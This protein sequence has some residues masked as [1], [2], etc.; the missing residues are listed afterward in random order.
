MKNLFKLFGIAAIVAVIGLSVAGCQTDTEDPTV[1]GV[2]VSPATVSVARGG[3]HTF[4]ATVTGTNNHPTTVT[5]AIVQTNTHAQTTINATTGVLNVAAAETLNTLTIRATSTFDTSRNGT[6]TVTLTGGAGEGPGEG[7]GPGNGTPGQAA[8][9]RNI[10]IRGAQMLMVGPRGRVGR[11]ATQA[12]TE[13]TPFNES[14]L[15]LYMQD[16][17]GEWSEVTMTGDGGAL[18]VAAPSEIMELTG[19]WVVMR[20]DDGTEHLVCRDQGIVFSVPGGGLTSRQHFPDGL[21]HDGV[22]GQGNH[23]YIW[24]LSYD[25]SLVHAV[26]PNRIF[27]M[28]RNPSNNWGIAEVNINVTGGSATLTHITP[29]TWNV[30]QF[31]VDRAGNILIDLGSHFM[32]R[33]A[34][35]TGDAAQTTRVPNGTGNIGDNRRHA[36]PQIFSGLDGEI[37]LIVRQVYRDTAN[38][39]TP[40]LPYQIVTHGGVRYFY[41]ARRMRVYRMRVV[42]GTFTATPVPMDGLR[43]RALARAGL[44]VTRNAAGWDGFD[45]ATHG[46]FLGTPLTATGN[47]VFN[48]IPLTSAAGNFS[49]DG[50]V[51]ALRI[52]TDDYWGQGF[53]MRHSDFAFR[54]GD[55]V[56]I[57]GTVTGLTDIQQV[58]LNS[59]PGAY[60]PV[61]GAR[62]FGDGSFELT[63][64]LTQADVTSIIA[65]NPAA[66]RFEVRGTGATALVRNV[67]VVRPNTGVIFDLASSWEFLG[68]AHHLLDDD[69]LDE[70]GLVRSWGSFSLVDNVR[71]LQVVTTANWGQGVDLSQSEFDLSPGDRVSVRG[72][73][74]GLG[75]GRVTL[76][77]SP[78]AERFVATHTGSAQYDFE[79]FEF[80]VTLTQ[81]DVAAIN[82]ATP[83]ALRLEIRETGAT[84]R[85]HNIRVVRA[86]D[87][88]PGEP[89]NGNGNGAGN[90]NGNG[91]G[92]EPGNGNGNG[93][94]N[95]GDPVSGIA[96]NTP[97][98]WAGIDR[99]FH[100]QD[101]TVIFERDADLDWNSEADGIIISLWRR[102][103]QHRISRG[104][105]GGISQTQLNQLDRDA[106]A[107]GATEV[108]ITAGRRIVAINPETNA[109]RDVIHPIVGETLHSIYRT[110]VA[111]YDVIAQVWT[112]DGDRQLLQFRPGITM[113]RVL[114]AD[115]NEGEEITMVRLR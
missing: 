28:V 72:T 66:L 40:P 27:V 115:L 44:P 86:G 9:V 38:W 48:N 29:P 5:W 76:N 24:H 91:N 63:A 110:E 43:S 33:A 10:D 46:G 34:N 41:Y 97:S 49:I 15:A 89:G 54:A 92:G 42:G 64:T 58:Q 60:R 84:A 100:F 6:A 35:A 74:D 99:M 2:A 4:S 68:A 39:P 17:A 73:V 96:V 51:R 16:A 20:W 3:N 104:N 75:T 1:T 107:S 113:P 95:G 87:P 47:A 30:R 62:H 53:D 82:A 59:S 21:P 22:P 111:G 83:P 18:Q 13:F 67:R 102:N 61:E 71:A 32:M 70:I 98:Y 81:Q 26:T 57:S 94:G 108:F 85:I 50:N 25:Q 101:K 106:V 37:Y 36:I 55:M 31:A 69:L 109:F 12:R 45:L 77:A 56:S 114:R 23:T 93:G 78:G 112:L 88:G 52:I 105:T 8:Q 14:D 79:S 7:P 11:D 80:D 65:S 90:G 103:G 19:N